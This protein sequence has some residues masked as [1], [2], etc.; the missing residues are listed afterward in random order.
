VFKY[1][2]NGRPDVLEGEG[3]GEEEEDS[4]EKVLMAA[5]VTTGGQVLRLLALLVQ[6]HEY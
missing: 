1:D 6:K 4:C 2:C 3:E 5:V